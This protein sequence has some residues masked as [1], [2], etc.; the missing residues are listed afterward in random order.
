MKHRRKHDEIKVAAYYEW[1]K[2]GKIKNDP[3][4]LRHWFE[5]KKQITG[6]NDHHHVRS[7]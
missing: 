3:H 5:G 1:V 6:R 7:S 2:R 4:T